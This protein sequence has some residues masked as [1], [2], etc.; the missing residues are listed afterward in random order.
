MNFLHGWYINEVS[1]RLT[2]LSTKSLAPSNNME[3]HGALSPIPR[4][5]TF[6]FPWPTGEHPYHQ[7]DLSIKTEERGYEEASPDTNVEAEVFT[8]VD[9]FPRIQAPQELAMHLLRDSW[10]IFKD[11]RLEDWVK[12]VLGMPCTAISLFEAY[13]RKL[14]LSIYSFLQKSPGNG[15]MFQKVAKVSCDCRIQP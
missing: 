3:R 10:S 6:H 15:V 14:G 11:L 4:V 5:S 13:H 2:G 8:S 1:S 12:Y 7:T 9:S